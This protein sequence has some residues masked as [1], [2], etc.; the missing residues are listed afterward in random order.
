[1]LIGLITVVDPTF[2]QSID[3]AYY[4]MVL[5]LIALHGPG[6]LSIDNLAVRALE[7]RFPNLEGMRGGSYEGMPRVVIVGGGF[8]GVAAAKA[9]H[10]ASCR[11]TLIDQRNY[12][13]FQPLLYQVA[14]AGLSPADI[15]GPLRN[16]FRDQPN[17]RVL[18]GSVTDVDLRR[19][20]VVTG[21]G[22]VPYDYLVIAAGARHSYFGHDEWAPFAPGLKQID[23]ATR[24][25][26][27]LLLAFEQAENAES[28]ALRREM[29]TFVIVGGGPTGVELAGA[30]AELARHGLAHEFRQI[31]PSMAR[32]ILMQAGPR[33]LP[34]FP[35][36]LSRRASEA[37]TTLGVEVLTDSAVELIDGAGVVV[38]GQRVAARNVFWAAGVMASAAAKWLKAGADRA[39]RVKVVEDLS[40]PGLPEVFAI[41]D[42]ALSNGWNGNPVPGL[43]P[44]AKQQGRYVAAVIKSRIAGG[45]P[46]A[47]F[48]Y[49][50]AG[51][52]ATIGRKA[53]VADFGRLR[54]SG[55]LAWWVWGAVHIL[56]LSGLR[57][58]AVVAL[59]WF[60]AYLTYHPSTRLITGEIPLPAR[61]AAAQPTIPVPAPVAVDA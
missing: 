39:G 54:L 16:L 13:L 6:V 44:A 50:H 5:G 41:G 23:D 29:L 49:R 11:V 9:F 4:L 43:A 56:F 59:E 21:N 58:R 38:A 47:P 8:G 17:V 24:I 33:I 12:C 57:N 15:A 26:S 36:S 40:V 51:S 37:L 18:L 22:C 28:A 25:R 31:D 55:A 45:P 32:V 53:A 27:R 46:P 19:R 1:M 30:I 10:N 60:W 3:L 14:T 42:T 2:Q 35:E 61:P 20:E 34:T 7:R 48:R 52:L